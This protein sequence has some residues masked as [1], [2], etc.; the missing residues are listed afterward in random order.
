MT[1]RLIQ[2]AAAALRMSNPGFK[3]SAPSFPMLALDGPLENA[4]PNPLTARKL[5]KAQTTKTPAAS[6]G[7]LAEQQEPHYHGH[8]DRLRQRFRDGGADALP[9]YELM[10][11]IL[12]RAIPRRDCKPLAKKIVGHFGSFTEACNASLESLM[13]VNG[14]GEAVATEIKLVHAAA[15]RFA[16]GDLSKKPLLSHWPQILGYLRAAL[17]L[18]PKEQFRVLFLDKRCRLIAEEILSHGSVDHAPVYVRDVIKRALH[19][20]ASG[21]ILCHNHPTGDP[22]PSKS[23]VALTLAIAEAAKKLDISVLDHLVFGKDGHLSLKAAE[24]F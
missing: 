17:A 6:P 21:L 10:E 2:P 13:E 12:F 22:T 5:H 23:D 20:E 4:P 1:S 19:H 18:E 16:K 3:D 24:M 15:M 11:L 8:R 9:D 7:N 14:V